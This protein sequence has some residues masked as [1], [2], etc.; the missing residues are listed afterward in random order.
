MR[1]ENDRPAAAKEFNGAVAIRVLVAD[2]HPVIRIGLENLLQSEPGIEVVGEAGNGDEAIARTLEL[3]PDILLLAL[4]LPNMPGLEAMR[5]VVNRSPK[6]KIIL[7]SNVISQIE[8]VKALQL[9]AVGIVVKDGRMDNLPS[10]IRSVSIGKIWLGD[11]R[12][13]NL[14][15]ALHMAEQKKTQIPEK[16]VVPD[17]TPRELDVVSCIVK[18]CS[19]RDIAHQFQLSEETVKR[20]LSNIFDKTGVSTRL[21]LALFAIEHQLVASR[22]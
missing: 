14:V 18:G 6:T 16:K 3:R 10:A 13:H 22:T 4:N 5:D 17:L 19:N 1:A 7:L 21:E 8:I 2:Q 12:V 15:E 9:G 11:R 20:H